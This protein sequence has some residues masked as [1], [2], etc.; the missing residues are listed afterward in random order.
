M[1][2]EKEYTTLA[3]AQKDYPDAIQAKLTHDPY[4]MTPA[5][6]IGIGESMC[7]KEKSKV[8]FYKVGKCVSRVISSREAQVEFEKSINV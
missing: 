2:E 7:H 3:Q 6:L 1:K 4:C 8:L 5:I